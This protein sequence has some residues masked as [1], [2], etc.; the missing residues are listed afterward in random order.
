MSSF[1]FAVGR[2]IARNS[3]GGQGVRGLSAADLRHSILRSSEFVDL[4]SLLSACWALGVAVVHLR[5]FPLVT[6]S[7]H[8]M[9]VGEGDSGVVMLGRD[10]S[11]P[12]P[13]AFTL[14][15]EIGHLA[16]GHVRDD[17]ILVDVEDPAHVRHRDAEEREADEFALTLLTGS[18]APVILTNAERYNAPTLA[19]AVLG[20]ASEYRIEPG[21][22]ALCVGYR[23]KN[24]PV[25]MSSFSFIYREK[26][27]VWKF[28][29]YV[30]RTQINWSSTRE[31]ED[32]FLKKLLDL[33]D[34]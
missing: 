8:A 28:I 3:P 29:N 27:Q 12:A 2:I 26:T 21:T 10:A 14:A 17:S 5:I 25:V 33:A 9:V 22:L 13:L 34:V 24:W 20:A 31:D 15:H 30:A 19:T 18:S 7:M 16:L 1:A 6:K 23:D 11:Y 32:D 4:Q